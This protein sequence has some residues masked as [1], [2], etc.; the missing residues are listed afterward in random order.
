MATSPSLEHDDY[1]VAL[2]YCYVAIED[3]EE[4]V[5]FHQQFESSLGGRIRIAPEGLNGVLSGLVPCLRSYEDALRDLL[6]SITAHEP[7]L[8]WELDVK[9]CRLR[10]DLPVE[11]QLFD[12]WVV[13]KTRH[14][15]G[16]VN[17][18]PPPQ[19]KRKPK[20]K[21]TIM[22]P[23]EVIYRES[24]RQDR[25]APHLSPADW[26]QKLHQTT[27]ETNSNDV[28][29]IDC[30]NAYESAIGHFQVPGTTTLLTNTRKYAELA[31]ILL[32]QKGRIQA[33]SHVF[34]YCTGGVRCERA[35]GFLQSMLLQEETTE[36]LPEIYQLHGGIQRYLEHVNITSEDTGDTADAPAS[37]YRGKNFVFD[38]RR[39]DPLTGN[40]SVVVGR[41]R[42]C[43]RPHDDYDNGASPA[44]S[45]P[46]RC[47]RCRV[48]LLVC[49]ACRDT[50]ECWG[51]D[52][53][54]TTKEDD[55][56]TQL[57]CGGSV[58]VHRPPPQEIKC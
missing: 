28:L 10:T 31:P 34:M 56:R 48:L 21:E 42:V 27:D 50:V 43:D 38:P 8:V 5:E 3:T 40:T 32:E 12:T 39:T 15:V 23:E 36:Q 44:E 37:Y 1:R 14:V 6:D 22:R 16:L 47:C 35:S 24:L 18:A 11:P 19:G 26:N 55:T 41:C 17:A 33:A 29:I 49:P 30:R 13:Q 4:V 54:T 7:G 51:D 52:T 53:N 57:L 45:H 46:A 2:Y 25:S 58:C 9:Y 20:A